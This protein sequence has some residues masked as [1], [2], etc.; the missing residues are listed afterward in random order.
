[1]GDFIQITEHLHA[2]DF[3][4]RF[5]NTYLGQA[6]LAGTGPTNKTCRE[7]RFWHVMEQYRAAP[8]R[9]LRQDEQGSPRPTEKGEVQ[10][11]DPRQGEP[12]H[13]AL[14]QRLPA[15]RAGRQP[16]V[17]GEAMTRVVSLLTAYV[18]E[19]GVASLIAEALAV[20]TVFAL[21]GVAFGVAW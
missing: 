16:A 21:L 4:E 14:R 19:H 8:P 18:A 12:A 15:V 10:R 6:H 7:C 1:M 20:V 17:R 3:D 9:V 5:R 13:P 11:A 2:C